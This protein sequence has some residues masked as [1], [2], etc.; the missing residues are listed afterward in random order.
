MK[1]S[2]FEKA[3]KLAIS[4]VQQR[5]NKKNIRF[6]NFASKQYVSAFGNLPYPN[7]S[8]LREDALRYLDSK[9][10]PITWFDTPVSTILNGERLSSGIPTST[11]DAF[12]NVN[13]K[14]ILS[15]PDETS[16]II[17]HIRTYN[18][19]IKDLREKMRKIEKT[20]LSRHAG[21]LIGNQT[22]DFYK[23]DG[24]TELEESVMANEVERRMNDDLFQDENEGKVDISRNLAFVGCVSNFS[25]FLD[26]FRKV[27]RNVE[28]GVPVVV[29]GR[30]NTNQHS[31]RWTE[32]LVELMREEDVDLGMVT[33]ACCSLNDIKKLLKAKE[34][35]P[36]YVTC[37]RV[38]AQEIK[39]GHE[40]TIA[41]TG[42]P[43]TLFATEW[44]IE[45]AQALTL[46]ATIESSGQCT[47]L[48]HA[49]LPGEVNNDDI[50][51][52]FNN[53]ASIRKEEVVESLRGEKFA[54]IIEGNN[55][56]ALP[57]G[58]KYTKHPNHNIWYHLQPSLPPDNIEE[59]W[60]KVV[61]DI[62]TDLDVVNL[63]RWLVRNQP[64]SLAINTNRD[65][66]NIAMKLFENTALVVYT[67]GSPKNPS[68]TCQ[69]RPQNGEIFGEFP[70]RKSLST[71]TKYPVIVPSST[72]AYDTSYCK[73]YLGN[74]TINSLQEEL[75][76]TKELFKAIHSSR[77]RGYCIE[78]ANYLYEAVGPK[79]GD[80]ERT[81]IWGLQ[82]PP[83]D[84]TKTLI[85]SVPTDSHLADALLPKLL[86]FFITNA[87]SQVEV[88]VADDCAAKNL[89]DLVGDIIDVSIE[90]ESA[91]AERMHSQ[92]F[93]QNY[94]NVIQ[95][96]EAITTF[97]LVG[98]FVSLSFP[99]GH[100]K[101][102]EANDN[103]FVEFF[104]SSKKWLR[105]ADKF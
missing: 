53:V 100:I 16:A 105:I 62:T 70:V 1:K 72:P 35:G 77:V 11:I 54:A 12:Q 90:G 43:N 74:L 59:H 41:S 29:F 57:S 44:T 6:Y 22:M 83:L 82:R 7:V 37:S 50:K 27:I 102:T 61:V 75:R 49:V 52:M 104:Q 85:R 30:G 99:M 58:T 103:E 80:G 48:R 9:F 5:A 21:F 89:K 17:T 3:T 79:R 46:S 66:W 67:V 91:F 60:R 45:I 73:N 65:E 56:A 64:I 40:K 84:G 94:Y 28:V 86:P 51:K 34:D 71:F 10:D 13:G 15:T 93:D 38:L 26:L 4:S 23:Q 2:I 63:S 88:S 36:M 24:V 39:R 32:L 92:N 8:V 76:C 42:G 18:P 33:F 55:D 69:A 98:Q 97:P 25:N 81:V 19:P 87:R 101:S 68:L 95:A 31:Y 14:N 96:N 78:I 20:L 47:A